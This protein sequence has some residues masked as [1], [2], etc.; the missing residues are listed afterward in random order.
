MHTLHSRTS[1]NELKNNND[2][3]QNKDNIMINFIIKNIYIHRNKE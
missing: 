1:H 3:K 2:K